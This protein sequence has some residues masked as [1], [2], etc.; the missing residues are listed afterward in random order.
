MAQR[1][2]SRHA[3][4]DES[5]PKSKLPL[6]VI[7]SVIGFCVLGAAVY[8]LVHFV[9]LAQP[10]PTEAP[11]LPTAT[12]T[13]A[14]IPTEAPTEA[15]TEPDFAAMA[16]AKLATMSDREK[17]C[18]LFIVTP[19]TLTGVDGVT[20]A[21]DTTKQ[22]IADYPVAGIIYNTVNMESADQTREMIAKTQEY[23]SIPMFIAVD[24]EGGD[25]ARAAEKLGTTS[26]DP[27]YSYKAQGTE[28]AHDNAFTIG[29]DIKALGFNLDFAPVADVW[30]NPDNT[31]IGSRAYSDD[32]TEAAE[33]VSAAVSGF[34]ESGIICTLKH[35]P[36]HG[37]TA[38]DSHQTLAYVSS[39]E[40]SLKAGELLPFKSGIEAGADVVSS[41]DADYPA[42][43]SSK[44]VPSLLREYLG[45]DGLVITDS[46]KMGAITDNYDHDTIIKGLFDADI[47]L[48]LEPDDLEAYLVAIQNAIDNGVITKEQ[49]DAKVKK[50]LTLKYKKG[51]FDQAAATSATEAPTDAATEEATEDAT[52]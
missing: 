18:Q 35:F 4:P 45:Y 38:E 14:P 47:D 46:M 10:A 42:T 33:L 29:S 51:L 41:I 31:A 1:Y 50:I 30:T 28:V 43:L 9:L 19:E 16:E 24:E 7:L 32:Y 12:P 34:N 13:L 27:M 3:S 22:A 21:G 36:G 6:I 17:L 44:V 26:F 49:I 40:G 8:A 20:M 25:V 15:E 23:A 52:E 5:A 39:D 37:N 48:I 11:T 2:Q